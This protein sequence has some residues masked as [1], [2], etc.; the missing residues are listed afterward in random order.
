MLNRARA[1]TLRTF[2]QGS[3]TA[4]YLFV[5]SLTTIWTAGVALT[6]CGGDDN[7]ATESPPD[8]STDGSSGGQNDGGTDGGGADAGGCSEL[9]GRLAE[10][11]AAA[12]ACDPKGA[13]QCG[14]KVRDICCTIPVNDAN[15]SASKAF[16]DAVNT[17]VSN[18]CPRRI[19]HGC[20][21]DPRA[22]CVP[23]DGGGGTCQ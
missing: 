1:V 14:Q 9:A 17:Y 12:L 23:N 15:S 22:R 2:A 20:V 4:G 19:C 16:S 7:K 10:A 11:R 8:G 21:V 5:L 3:L 6:G 18:K 13:D